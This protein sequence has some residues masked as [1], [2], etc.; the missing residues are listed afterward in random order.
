MKVV[1]FFI[2]DRNMKISV[3][4]SCAIAMITSFACTETLTV[5]TRGA[6]RA[7]VANVKVH[8]FDNEKQLIASGTSNEQGIATFEGV[9]KQTNIFGETDED[10]GYASQWKINNRGEKAYLDLGEGNYKQIFVA[11]NGVGIEGVEVRVYTARGRSFAY[12]APIIIGKTDINGVLHANVP[13]YAHFKCSK[14][15]NYYIDKT[16]MHC[17]TTDKEVVQIEMRMGREM[18]FAVVDEDNNPM[19][20]FRARVRTHDGK[21]WQRDSYYK[22][23][24]YG[25]LTILGDIRNMIVVEPPNKEYLSTRIYLYRRIP[26]KITVLKGYA[27]EIQSNDLN[28]KPIRQRVWMYQQGNRTWRYLGITNKE[29]RLATKAPGKFNISSRP[30]DKGAVGSYL[31]NQLYQE[32]KVYQITATRLN[33]EVFT[34]SP[35]IDVPDMKNIHVRAF[36]GSWKYLGAGMTDEDGKVSIKVPSQGVVRLII[37]DKFGKRILSTQK[38]ITMQNLN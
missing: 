6:R 14:R 37:Q 3:L 19:A 38:E 10:S 29:G 7:P 8:I 12:N 22:V 9:P 26:N 34:L 24:E 30:L 31:R 5:Y 1:T 36:T 4:A 23:D 32:G 13:K 17:R 15:S 18:T 11:E 20:G 27:I 33:E 2:G 21:R 35:D 28:G 16:V 25:Y